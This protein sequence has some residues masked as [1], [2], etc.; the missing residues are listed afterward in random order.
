MNENEGQ[1]YTLET[2]RAMFRGRYNDQSLRVRVC[3]PKG[4]R[5]AG[6]VAGIGSLLGVV[7][8]QGELV[9]DNRPEWVE[10]AEVC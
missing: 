4:E 5:F 2:L 9:E 1:R 8:D 7:T 10:Y 3:T 6:R